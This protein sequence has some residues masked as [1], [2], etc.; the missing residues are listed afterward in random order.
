MYLEG[1][2]ETAKGFGIVAKHIVLDFTKSETPRDIAHMRNVCEYG[3]SRGYSIALD[4]IAS[5]ENA[6]K[7]LVQRLQQDPRVAVR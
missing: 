3:R 4:D 5:V 7:L 2:S 6:K 1:L